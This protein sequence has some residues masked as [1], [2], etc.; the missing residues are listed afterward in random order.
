MIASLSLLP[1]VFVAVAA[2]TGLD[3]WLRYAPIPE[4]ESYAGRLP[5]TVVAL[6]TSESSPVFVGAKEI[7]QGI[8][9]IFGIGCTVEHTD[10]EDPS[11]VL[12]GTVDH[13]ESYAGDK[14][15]HD[16][17]ELIEDGFYLDTTGD[18]V[19]ILG[20]NERGAL[21]GAFEYLS[22]LAQGNV[23]NVAYASNPEVPIRW[24]N[25]W[26]NL[27][28]GGTHGSVERG[29]G[30]DSLFFWDGEVR[31]DLT[32]AAQYARLLA[33]IGINAVIVNNVN[34]NETILNSTNLDGVARIADVFRPYGVQLGLS[35]YFASPQALG[36]LPTFDPLDE[37]V[38]DWWQNITDTIYDKI[39]DFAG[40]L[41]K[42][43][44][45]GQP[46]PLTYNRT[47]AQGANLFAR[48]LEPHGGICMFRAFV[49]DS[50]N[51]N[52]T[53]WKDDRAN[54]AVDFFNGLDSEF[55]HDNVVIQIKYGVSNLPSILCCDY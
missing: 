42:A 55:I 37:Q 11:G 23:S 34:A 40:Y 20:L 29:Y 22:L 41:V 35:L 19:L 50:K 33:S 54:A 51:L 30:G 45:E 24:I 6:N 8:A 5:T 31:P 10:P 38:I 9:S 47:L 48:A 1:L 49:Y 43:N 4:A 53:N 39:P 52:E 44:S 25:Q 17:P 21:Y 15:R 32:R 2:E 14:A 13:Y 28:D 27:R 46:G 16:I 18:Q 7:Q 12:I 3:G 36:K 26:D